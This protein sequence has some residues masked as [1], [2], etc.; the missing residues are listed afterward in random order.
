MVEKRKSLRWIIA[1]TCLAALLLAMIA[2]P[3]AAQVQPI[4]CSELANY[5]DCTSQKKVDIVV[6]FDT[7]GSMGGLIGQMK[8]AVNSFADALETS[9]IDYRLGLTEFR[10]YSTGCNGV[11][12]WEGDFP[13]KLYPGGAGGL[14]ADKAIFQSWVNSLSIGSGNDYEESSLA[15]LLHTTAG[16]PWRGDASKVIILIT[17]AP[18]HGDGH[19]CNQEGETLGGTISALNSNGVKVFAITG[20]SYPW[21][22]VVTETGGELYNMGSPLTQILSK[23]ASQLQ[24]SFTI[25]ATGSCEGSTLSVCAKFI[26]KGGSTIPYSQGNTD[27]RMTVVCPDGTTNSYPL[28]YSPQSNAYCGTVEVCDGHA[29]EANV[30]VYGRVCTFTAQDELDKEAG[31]KLR[32]TKTASSSTVV[33]GENITYTI[34]V[35]NI[36]GETATDVLVRDVFDKNV[37]FLAAYPE[38]VGDGIWHIDALAPGECFT[39]TLLVRVPQQDMEYRGDSGVKGTGYANV[40]NKYDTTLQPYVIRNQVHVSASGNIKSLASANVTVVKDLGTDLTKHEHG[41]G[42]YLAE[43]LAQVRL[44]NKS[45][46]LQGSL[47]ADYTP[48]NFALPNGRSVDYKSRWTEDM[49]ARNVVTGSTMRNSIRYA[50]SLERNVSLML[51]KNGSILKTEAEFTGQGHFGYLKNPIFEGYGL[52]E[53]EGKPTFESSEDLA[54]N[55]RVNESFDEYGLSVIST[56]SISGKGQASS[57]KRVRDTQRSYEYGS[58]SIESDEVITTY[59]NFLAKNLKATYF[60]TSYVYSPNFQAGSSTKWNE[61]VWTKS[62]NSTSTGGQLSYSTCLGSDKLFQSY[63]GERI[64]NA[65]YLEKETTVKG[66]YSLKSEMNFSGQA[67]FKTILKNATPSRGAGIKLSG[68][69]SNSPLGSGDEINIDE[70]YI[71]QYKISRNIHL[72]GPSK[73]N[74][75][76]LTVEMVGRLDK[77]LINGENASIAMY[78]I[79]IT[80]DGD[81]DMGPLNVKDFFPPDTEYINSSLRPGEVRSNYANWIVGYLS[82]SESITILLNLKAQDDVEDL[83]NRVMVMGGYEGKWFTASKY[84]TIQGSWLSC[85]SP[86]VSLIKTAE[87]D[88]SDPALVIY[89]LT[90]QNLGNRSLAATITDYLPEGMTFVGASLAPSEAEDGRIVWV[91][92]DI[93]PMELRTMDYTV[94]ASHD[95]SYTNMAHVDAT[96]LDGSSTASVDAEASVVISGSSSQPQTTRYDSWQPPNWDFKSSEMGLSQY[97]Q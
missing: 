65:N 55:F 40:Y 72:K 8:S 62:T 51:D 89:R 43:E 56:S 9:D 53:K 34:S 70:G 67:E 29:C 58:G 31:P 6:V 37:E 82:M 61:G 66:A 45:I 57:D 23:I 22:N 25:D 19:C 13:Y 18:P 60:P 96:L 7:T 63:F 12:G 17:D 42:T 41:S 20:V 87:V 76:H 4:P 46:Q 16:E 59:N 33:R 74:M 97:P 79:T 1:E 64:S 86:Q 35:C 44:K 71:G 36:G 94:R 83:V 93:S 5:M 78:A 30:T 50:Q 14:T 11:C 10:D 81:C 80:N 3:A 49:R 48:T 21:Q 75:P 32:V 85:C 38:P 39:I 88:V 54:G 47:S 26:G 95:G 27:A 91:L 28:T 68:N 92:P 73:Y 84:S 2:T 69:A 77:S 52:L 15:A 90:F 24:C